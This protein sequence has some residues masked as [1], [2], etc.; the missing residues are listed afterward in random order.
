[1]GISVKPENHSSLR[2]EGT[3]RMIE[4]YSIISMEMVCHQ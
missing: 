1:M 2:P 4:G 3:A